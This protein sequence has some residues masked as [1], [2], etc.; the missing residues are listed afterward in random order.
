MDNSKGKT[1]YVEAME[2]GVRTFHTLYINLR[3]KLSTENGSKQAAVEELKDQ[4][5]EEVGL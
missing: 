3:N 5:E 2:M 4:I 1:S